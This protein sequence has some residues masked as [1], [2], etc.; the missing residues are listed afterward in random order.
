MRLSAWY[1]VTAIVSC[2]VLPHAAARA[3]WRNSIKPKG[4]PGPELTLARD[5]KTNCVIVIP[6]EST[7]QEQKAAEELARWLG[8]MTGAAFEI[9]TDATS[10]ID[11]EISVGR[12]NRLEGANVPQVREDLG[13]EGYA[14][15]VDGKRL[16]LVGG[17]SRGPIYAVYALLEEDLGCRWYHLEESLIPKSATLRFR[18][19]PRHYVPV[20]FLRDPFYSDAFNPTWSLRNRTNAPWAPV[21]AEWGGRVTYVPGFVHTFAAL[22]PRDQYFDEH[23]EYFALIDGVRDP[24][25]LC[26]THP[27]VIRIVTERMLKVLDENPGATMLEISPNDGGRHCTC[28]DCEKLNEENNSPA[29]S[30][31]YFVNKIAEA[32]EEK[33]PDVLVSTLAYLDTVDAPTKIK[34]RHN[35]A[36]RLCNDLHAWNYP[37]ID[38]VS[39][40]F[41]KSK[42]YRDAIIGWSN[43]CDKITI[44]DYYTNFRHYL[45]P[46]PN[47]NVLKPSVDFYVAH[48]VKGIMF[49]GAYQGPG[50]ER[51]AMRA[52]VIAKL[53][54]DPSRDVAELIDDFVWGY[55]QDAAPA[56]LEYYE[57]LERTRVQHLSEM[58]DKGFSYGMDVPM[59]SKEFLGSAT[60]LLKQA[61]RLAQSDEVRR[62]V[63][64]EQLPIMYV[65]LMQGPEVTGEE[66]ADVLAKFEEIAR[67]EN[68]TFLSEGAP[69]LGDKLSAWHER[70]SAAQKG[71]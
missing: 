16:F 20:L 10:P 26:Q 62:R 14:I 40:D 58:V 41:E 69:D 59:F 66:Y 21:Q 46:M 27:D 45:A 47:M 35:V 28:P 19:V 18:P 24:R 30:L 50:G 9:V 64:L 56:I 15:A 61:E 53:L 3:E 67:R 44:W 60:D 49:Q 51:A 7:G 4:E 63:E 1:V 17:R 70:L 71:G 31:I 65:K 55:Y 6:A 34:P 32:V 33:R 57:L 54:W 2:L 42:Q 13:N 43:I 37:L 38:F 48:N 25:Q 52:W 29:G 8:E 39:S 36:V 12:T 22:L 23:P 5:G 68:V 11:T